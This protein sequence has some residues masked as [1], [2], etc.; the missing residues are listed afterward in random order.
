MVLDCL[1][2]ERI[3]FP[4]LD[5]DGF[6][7][8]LAQAGAKPIA[9]AFADEAGFAIYDLNGSFSAG[10]HAVAT[11]IAFLFIYLDHLSHDSCQHCET[12]R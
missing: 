9:I 4:L 3:A 1:L 12:S 7:R 8:T 11:A 2:I 10:D 5:G 6:L